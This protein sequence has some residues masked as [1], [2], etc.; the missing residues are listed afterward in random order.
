MSN[1]QNIR[2]QLAEAIATAAHAERVARRVRQTIAAK[3][4]KR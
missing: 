1:S 3:G 2:E 4:S